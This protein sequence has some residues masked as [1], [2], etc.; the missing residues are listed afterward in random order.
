MLCIILHTKLCGKEVQAR[1]LFD[2]F[3]QGIIHRD[4]KPENILVSDDMKSLWLADFNA[5][6]SLLEGRLSALQGVASA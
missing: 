5:A 6:H 4:V 3:L 2:V 1:K